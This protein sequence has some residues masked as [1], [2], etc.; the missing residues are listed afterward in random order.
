MAVVPFIVATSFAA[1]L[2]VYATVVTLGLL[3]RA[4]WVELPGAL[5]SLTNWWVLAGC[6]VMLLIEFVADK[7][8][9][10]DLIWN[11]VQTAVRVP[12]GALIAYAAATPLSSNEQLLAGLAGAVIALVAHGG[13][14]AMRTAVSASPE[15]A[16][17]IVLSLVE[18]LFAIGLTWFA[19]SHPYLAATLAIS[20]LVVM[21]FTVRWI[22]RMIARRF[23]RQPEVIASVLLFGVLCSIVH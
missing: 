8:P 16:S 3:G 18:D 11:V 23:R 7:V 12:A 4:G 22:V 2:N 5:S 19:T 10:I 15:P 6:G 20:V 1:G 17:N 21:A 9:V 13:K 14:L